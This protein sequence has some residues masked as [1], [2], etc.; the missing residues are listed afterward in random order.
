M[1][2]GANT[3]LYSLFDCPVSFLQSKNLNTKV[4][5][6][7]RVLH[8]ARYNEIFSVLLEF[9]LMNMITQKYALSASPINNGENTIHHDSVIMFSILRASSTEN[10]V[11]HNRFIHIS[12]TVSPIHTTISFNVKNMLDLSAEQSYTMNSDVHG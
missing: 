11:R 10:T 2:S 5:P 4:N 6:K 7:N 8:T 12:K 1:K 9:I 3:S